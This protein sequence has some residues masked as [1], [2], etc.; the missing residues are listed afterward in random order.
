MLEDKNIREIVMNNLANVNTRSQETNNISDVYDSH[1]YKDIA[2]NK[3]CIVLTFHFN[4]D[5]FP[6]FKSNKNSI[7]PVLLIINDT[8]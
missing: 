6:V 4:T 1:L 2:Q 8:A 7:W 5:G 3:K